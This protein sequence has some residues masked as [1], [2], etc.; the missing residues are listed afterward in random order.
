MSSA[1][2][3]MI[4]FGAAFI[5]AIFPT[6]SCCLRQHSFWAR[7]SILQGS[8]A[9]LGT[10]TDFAEVS[11]MDMLADSI[12]SHDISKARWGRRARE[13]VLRASPYSLHILAGYGKRRSVRTLGPDLRC[14]VGWQ[15]CVRSLAGSKRLG[16]DLRAWIVDALIVLCEHSVQCW[17]CTCKFRAMCVQDI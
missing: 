17:M 16:A 2:A 4:A 11:S 3:A 1:A 12:S 15:F 7:L 8:G 14:P 13:G 6:S 10:L 5:T 9:K